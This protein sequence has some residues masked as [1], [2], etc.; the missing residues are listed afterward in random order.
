MK[1]EISNNEKWHQSLTLKLI[2]L[3]F[4]SLFLL[5]PMELIKEIIKERQATAEGVQLEIAGQWAMQQTLEGPVLNIPLRSV[6]QIK[7]EKP[8]TSIW[9]LLPEKLNVNGTID[10]EMRYRGIY[11]SVVYKSNLG[12]TGEFNLDISAIP[13]GNEILWQEA[14]ITLGISDNR[15]VQGDILLKAGERE[16]RAEPGVRDNDISSSGITFKA[17]LSGENEV[18]AF[19]TNFNLA[20]S[21]S[22]FVTPVGK[23]TEVRLASSWNDPAF[24]GNFLPTERK[25]DNEGFTALWQVT[26][27][28][29]NFPQSWQGKQYSPSGSSFGAELLLQ[30]DHYQKSW[31]SARYGILFIALTFLV[32]IFLEITRKEPVHIIHYLL[33]SL[34]LILFF[35]L[36]N[37][38]S[39]HTGFN[40]AYLISSVSTVTLITL[41]TGSL[42]KEKRV[43]FIIG[44]ILTALYGFIFVL[45]SLSD[46][47]YLAGNIGL[48]VL[49]AIIMR[50][51][52]KMKLQ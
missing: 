34:S 45:L 42:M 23:V 52:A 49:L 36:L 22:L 15:G 21:E 40:M 5:I 18:I 19:S 2:L 50:L 12:I 9:H 43:F 7:D 11:Q 6:P 47:A 38:L 33:V 39:E 3:A 46:Y 20:G 14:Y 25:V 27:L 48:F 51:A 13:G 8:V 16:L 17:P 24:S 4:L 26:H 44:G 28:N 1:I 10:P 30:A 35:S 37:S 41:F 31:R 29:R 32:I